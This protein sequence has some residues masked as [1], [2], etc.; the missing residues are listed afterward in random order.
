V[1][2]GGGPPA[3][4]LRWT[5]GDVRITSVVETDG[6]TPVQFLFKG[7]TPEQVLAHDWLRPHFAD[8]RGRLISRV[9]LLLI[10][11]EG[12][13]IAVDTCLGNDKVRAVPV[14]SMRT[15]PFLDWVRGAGF[16]PGDVDFVAC[17]HLHVDHVGWNTMLVD[18][19][20]VPTFPNARYVFGRAEYEHWRDTPSNDGDV[21]GDSVRP[22]MEAGLADLVEDHHAF[23]SE[24]SYEP[25]PG[26]TP[27]HQSVRIRSCGEDAVITG[28]LM[29]HPIQCAELDWG[30]FDT[31]AALARATRRAFAAAQATNGSLVIGTHFGAPT[32]GHIRAHGDGTFRFE[33]FVAETS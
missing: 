31:D 23:T 7:A 13:L 29:H 26:H 8:E 4:T 1:S 17:T 25:T 10:E 3:P 33:A 19:R 6:P 20:W 32:A 14:W 21:F 28:D 30:A 18:G 2:D 11:S 16:D 12:K 27:G 9:Q 15:E 24:V 5:V 22:I